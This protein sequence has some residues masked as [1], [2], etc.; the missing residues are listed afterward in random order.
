ML[1]FSQ[2]SAPISLMNHN[3]STEI[4]IG[5]PESELFIAITV[6]L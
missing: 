1:L 2:L 3:D 5:V 4:E 6:E